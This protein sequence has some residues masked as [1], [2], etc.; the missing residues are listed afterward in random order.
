MALTDTHSSAP[1]SLGK[2]LA[3]PFVAIGNFLVAMMENNSR[4]QHVQAL[5]ALSDAELAERGLK[6]DDIVAHVFRDMMHV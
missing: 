5:N 6:R 3:A 1:L 2:I 4:V